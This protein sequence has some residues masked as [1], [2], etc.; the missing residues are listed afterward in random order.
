M[1]SSSSTTSGSSSTN[2]NQAVSPWGP[3]TPYITGAFNAAANAANQANSVPLPSNFTAQMTPDQINAYL[4]MRN[5]GNVNIGTSQGVANTGAGV[6]APGFNTALSTG[7]SLA[8]FNPS[9]TN[10]APSVL[11]TAQQYV[12]G[13]N[14]PAQVQ[15]AMQTAMET[16]RDVTNPQTEN[17]AASTGNI[18][19]SRTGIAQGL[20]DRGL[21]ETAA[22][23]SGTLQNQ[24]WNTGTNLGETMAGL[25]NQ[26]QISA[27]E[28]AMSGG[29]GLG[30]SG[31]MANTTGLKDVGNAENLAQTGATGA[32]YTPQQLNLT[33]QLQQY[34]AGTQAPFNALDQLWN[35]IGSRSWGQNTTGNQN[36]NY[37]Q[38]T[39]NTPSAMQ[40][41]GST[42]GTLG[43][44]GLGGTGGILGTN[45]FLANALM[46]SFSWSGN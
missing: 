1:G 22:N 38:T 11:G 29:I 3:Q 45:G 24:A 17:G 41:I 34:Q 39:T 13:L 33:N 23:L 28:A 9:S 35:I 37:T 26:Q 31:V 20:V 8:G 14:I 7:T 32:T 44:A 2:Y 25:N 40:M 36:T 12:N 18:N 42:L 4:S 10:N 46:P 15:N 6:V 19:S 16:A 43:S 30:N 21:A 5:S 27:L